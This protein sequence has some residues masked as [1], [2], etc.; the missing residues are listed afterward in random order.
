MA[1]QK[2]SDLQ[3][4]IVAEISEAIEK[5]GGDPELLAVIGSWGDTL[6]E[7]EVLQGL[8]EYNRRGTV[9]DFVVES[10]E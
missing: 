4:Q 7:D 3:Y 2:L 10:A 8:K 6:T 1:V 9:F 5:L